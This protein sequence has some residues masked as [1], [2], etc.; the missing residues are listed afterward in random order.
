MSRLQRGLTGLSNVSRGASVGASQMGNDRQ[1]NN[2]SFEE[3]KRHIH[4]K[5]V[6]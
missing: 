1:N 2:R 5:L 6:E 4:Q 3:L